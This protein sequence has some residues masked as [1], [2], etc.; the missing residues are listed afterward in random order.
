LFCTI[1]WGKECK[2]VPY[3]SETIIT[4]DIG[5]N[6][7]F[8]CGSIWSFD[9]EKRQS[10]GVIECSPVDTPISKINVSIPY[11]KFSETEVLKG[12]WNISFYINKDAAEE[13]H[14]YTLDDYLKAKQGEVI[15][16]DI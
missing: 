14:G 6:E 16:K 10:I 7:F 9:K 3:V 8:N 11:V 2:E 1:H 5:Y 4:T 13:K 12:P 15:L